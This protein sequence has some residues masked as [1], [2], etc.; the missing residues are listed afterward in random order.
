[1]KYPTLSSDS[2]SELLRLKRNGD[3]IENSPKIAWVGDGAKLTRDKIDLA[4]KRVQE[5]KAKYPETLSA[6]GKNGFQFETEAGEVLR[7]TLDFPPEIVADDGF[8]RYLAIFHFYDVVVWRHPS[9]SEE[10]HTKEAN[11]GIGSKWE[12]LV[13]R[14][15]YRFEVAR[16]DGAKDPYVLCR[17]GDQDLWRS[18]ILRVRFS[19]AR[20]AVKA[21]LKY[22]YP[23]LDSKKPRLSTTSD[24]DKG[25]RMLV[26]IVRRIHATTV[27]EV[28]SLDEIVSLMANAGKHLEQVQ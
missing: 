9:G 27:L 8:W 12:N 15:W 14:M 24:K 23:D 5:I 18:H 20:H 1:M 7:E 25:I 16:E 2:A 28:M 3:S 19:A 17:L 13:K 11:F 4:V 21:L 6:K 22:Q 26:K 10:T